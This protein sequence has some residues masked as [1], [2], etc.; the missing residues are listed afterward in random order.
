VD[1]E[2]GAYSEDSEGVNTTHRTGSKAMDEA[3][4]CTRDLDIDFPL[5][6]GCKPCPEQPPFPCETGFVS[7]EY[8]SYLLNDQ[9]EG[10]EGVKECPGYMHQEWSAYSMAECRPCPTLIG[11]DPTNHDAKCQ[12]FGNEITIQAENDGHNYLNLAEII[13]NDGIPLTATMSDS[14]WTTF[15]PSSCVDGNEGN[16]C[17]GQIG[18]WITVKL[19]TPSCIHNIRVVNRKD[20]CQDRILG[21]NI[22]IKNQGVSVW[23]GG[24]K[25]TKQ[26]YLFEF[27]GMDAPY[28]AKANVIA[29]KSEMLAAGWSWTGCAQNDH[30]GENLLTQGIWCHSQKQMHLKVPSLYGSGRCTATWSNAYSNTGHDGFV[31]LMKNG[32][33]LGEAKAHQT[34]TV[35]FDYVEGDEL[36]F[37]EGFAIAKTPQ[38]WLTCEAP[39]MVGIVDE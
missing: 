32:V 37:W 8:S 29:S 24:F 7:T 30:G 23:Q 16:F 34:K 35:T 17:H 9:V 33:Q 2:A 20:C 13:V 39:G 5:K 4:R 15:P 1:F 38:N 21:G 27:D 3:I 31:R 12:A 25:E 26:E 36:E 28:T 22:E 10:L 14:V 6:K 18:A 19:P 11:H